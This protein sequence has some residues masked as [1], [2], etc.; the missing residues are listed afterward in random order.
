MED[1]PHVV[2]NAIKALPADLEDRLSFA[3][4]DFLQPQAVGKTADAVLLRWVL[5]NWHDVYCERILRA[6]IPV[7]KPGTKVLI[8]EY[9]LDDAPVLDQ[10]GRFGL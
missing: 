3:T 4:Q 6:L 2:P 10:A 5:H 7:L 9:V 8:Y 1:L